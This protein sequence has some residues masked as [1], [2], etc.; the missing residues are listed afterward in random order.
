MAR[1]CRLREDTMI[2]SLIT[3]VLSFRVAQ[4]KSVETTLSTIFGNQPGQAVQNALDGTG[5]VHFMSINFI[6]GD[7]SMDPRLLMELSV[8]GAASPALEKVASAIK[9]QLVE[10]FRVADIAFR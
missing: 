9:P 1:G 3:V 5:I 6:R 2:H 8:D 4:I 7:S 10:L